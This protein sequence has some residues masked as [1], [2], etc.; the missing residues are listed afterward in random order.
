MNK[1]HMAPLSRLWQQLVRTKSFEAF[2]WFEKHRRYRPVFCFSQ[3]HHECFAT[4]SLKISKTRVLW[5]K[6]HIPMTL[7]LPPETRTLVTPP[8]IAS[9]NASSCV[10]KASTV[11][12]HGKIGPCLESSSRVP[13]FYVSIRG[14]TRTRTY[15]LSS[16]EQAR[17]LYEYRCRLPRESITVDPSLAMASLT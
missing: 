14:R 2:V 11:R 9:W 4:Y 12:S 10:L 8:A 1:R 16:L 3:F 17:H 7:E 13:A 5:K 15:Y 6:K